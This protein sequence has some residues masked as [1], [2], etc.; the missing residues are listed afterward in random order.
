MR[1][2]RWMLWSPRRLAAVVVGGLVLLALVGSVHG[3]HAAPSAHASVPPAVREQTPT[4]TAARGQVSSTTTSD[5][6]STKGA[7]IIDPAP[8]TVPLPQPAV[9]AATHFLQLWVSRAPQ[10]QWSQQ[11]APLATPQMGAG[12]AVADPGNVP[13]AAVTG[14]V[15]AAGDTGG[16]QIV[17][18]TDT[19][20]IVV[21]VTSALGGWLV[22][23][24]Q[25]LGN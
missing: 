4:S 20:K 3:H 19:G 10:P 17:A 13:A 21:T 2:L 15:S 25:P 6:G 22:S 1:V 5:A 12:L 11:L 7:R 16:G 14:I 24:L 8:T 23:D 9:D 18:Q